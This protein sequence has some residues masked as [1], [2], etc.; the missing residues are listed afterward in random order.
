MLKM[1]MILLNQIM[2]HQLDT[3]KVPMFV[4]LFLKPND[5]LNDRSVKSIY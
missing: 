3:R 4:Q 2:S 1:F 5:L